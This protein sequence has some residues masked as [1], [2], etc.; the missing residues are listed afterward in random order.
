[1]EVESKEV[2]PA[3]ACFDF[4]DTRFVSVDFQSKPLLRNHSAGSIRG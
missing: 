3:F 1:L 4:V 2:Q